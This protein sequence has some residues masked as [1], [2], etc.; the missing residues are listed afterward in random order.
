[1][2]KA[3]KLDTDGQVMTAL[4]RGIEVLRCFS[5]IETELS[6]KQLAEKTGLPKP[7]L[8]RITSTLRT[9]GLLRYDEA[10]SSF[11][12]AP[13]VLAL[14]A[15]VL[16]RLTLRQVARPL[17]QQLADYADAQLMISMGA[18]RDLVVVE[19][20]L[21]AQSAVFR[22]EIGARVSLSRSAVGRVYLL[23]L[24]TAERE[25]H[26]RRVAAADKERAKHLQT[27]LNVN[28]N[29]LARY[30]YCKA[31]GEVRRDVWGV[32][33]PM[34][35]QFDGQ[36][37][38]FSCSVLPFTADEALLDDLGNR[39]VSLVHTVEAALGNA[40]HLGPLHFEL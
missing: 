29:D 3:A 18:A 16:A 35:T 39:L 36:T 37:I 5:P 38:V 34:G 13:G 9:L 20:V 33:A 2:A 24:S 10:R 27:A 4:A 30:G 12:L 17:M 6:S 22:P 23:S 31:F 7:T 15:P 21:G 14:A 32:A 40:D 26:I 8:F 25:A 28:A 11:L 1:M 19:T